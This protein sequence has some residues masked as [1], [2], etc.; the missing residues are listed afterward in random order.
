MPL[1]QQR[2]SFLKATDGTQSLNSISVTGRMM[3][4][5][6]SDL[7]PPQHHVVDLAKRAIQMGALDLRLCIIRE[8]FYGYFNEGQRAGEVPGFPQCS[9]AA[10]VCCYII[11]RLGHYRM[12]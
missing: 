9:N 4:K 7:L 1:S 8:A 12:S 11:W 2:V 3:W 10:C 5:E 6:F